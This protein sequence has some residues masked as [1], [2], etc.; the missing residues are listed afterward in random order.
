MG[1]FVYFKKNI[2]LIF[3]ILFAI[4]EKRFLVK[5]TRQFLIFLPIEQLFVIN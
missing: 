4:L 1:L 3:F 5:K 2:P